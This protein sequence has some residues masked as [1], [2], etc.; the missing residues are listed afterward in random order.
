[1]SM[2]DVFKLPVF[3]ATDVF[4]MMAEDELAEL[5]EDMKPRRLLPVVRPPPSPAPPRSP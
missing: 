2:H 4:P 5:A 1:M 3:P